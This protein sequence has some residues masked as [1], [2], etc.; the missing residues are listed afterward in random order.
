ML[1]RPQCSCL[2][3]M[4]LLGERRDTEAGQKVGRWEERKGE[5]EGG[6]K[7]RTWTERKD[8]NWDMSLLA[9]DCWLQVDHRNATP[10]E[11][12]RSRPP[13]LTCPCRSVLSSMR[14]QVNVWAPSAARQ[15]TRLRSDKCH[16]HTL[17]NSPKCNAIHSIIARWEANLISPVSAKLDLRS[18]PIRCLSWLYSK[19][20]TLHSPAFLCMASICKHFKVMEINCNSSFF[21]NLLYSCFDI[22]YAC[23]RQRQQACSD[24][25]DLQRWVSVGCTG[26]SVW[27]NAQG[28]SLSPASP[29]WVEKPLRS[30]CHTQTNPWGQ[31]QVKCLPVMRLRKK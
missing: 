20:L 3:Q 16:A 12:R 2:N 23:H 22:S 1:A 18:E 25:S 29:P 7:N 10:V 14:A 9:K 28:P 13:V 4:R 5:T 24:D 31:Q 11:E 26:R 8:A 6:G 21:F 17:K 27:K 30:S 19:R 15:Y